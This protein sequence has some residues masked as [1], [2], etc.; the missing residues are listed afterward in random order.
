MAALQDFAAHNPEVSGTPRVNSAS[1]PKSDDAR[2]RAVEMVLRKINDSV[3]FR[4]RSDLSSF[5]NWKGN[6]EA[7]IHRWLRY[8]EAYS[9][10]LITKL[11]LGDNILDPFCGCGSILIG[12]AENG[13]TSAGIDINPLAIFAARVKLT[14][15][16]QTQLT[17][18][19]KYVD[20]LHAAIDSSRR[21]RSGAYSASC[22]ARTS[23]PKLRPK[24]INGSL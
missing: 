1:G 13:N 18:I 20:G 3:S 11:G 21:L 14:P 8:R 15:L 12:S 17:A 22:P 6:A 19:E 24:E 2:R 10:N 16:S 4:D 23:S 7:P 9:P 5:V